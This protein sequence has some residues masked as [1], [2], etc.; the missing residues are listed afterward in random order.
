M[1]Y[2]SLNYVV[3]PSPQMNRTTRLLTAALSLIM[4]ALFGYGQTAQ[5]QASKNPSVTAPESFVQPRIPITFLPITI[6]APGSYYLPDGMMFSPTN[7]NTSQIAISVNSPGKV[8]IDLNGF[9]LSAFTVLIL[10]DF[11]FQPT[12]IAIGSS[13]VTIKNGTIAGFFLCLTASGGSQ[14][15]I[16]DI[17]IQSLTFTEIPGFGGG[18]T[19]A[20]QFNNVNNSMVKDCNFTQ[21][22]N[23]AITDT[24]SQ[25]GNRYINDKFTGANAAAISIISAISNPAPIIVHRITPEKLSAAGAD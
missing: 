17:V 18:L 11:M 23:T 5:A 1:L 6:T 16:S 22:S 4:S 13:H 2:Q 3:L 9:T 7:A 15:Y 21:N 8:T 19:G 20:I 10:H 25:T 14:T 12:A 24:A